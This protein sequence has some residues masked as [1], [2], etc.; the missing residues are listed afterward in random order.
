MKPSG[1]TKPTEAVILKRGLEVAVDGQPQDQLLILDI[2]YKVIKA[3]FSKSIRFFQRK[4]NRDLPVL[5][6]I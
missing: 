1:Q 2:S 5:V 4:I 3:V 6:V